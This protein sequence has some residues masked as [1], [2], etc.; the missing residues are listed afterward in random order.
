MY[1]VL[2]GASL[3]WLHCFNI[4][5]IVV[6]LFSKVATCFI[7][8][9]YLHWY[10]PLQ[11]INNSDQPQFTDIYVMYCNQKF[12]MAETHSKMAENYEI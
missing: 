6:F 3:Q 10:V 5:L 12:K 8:I 7:I 9:L 4:V 1:I 11:H 2:N